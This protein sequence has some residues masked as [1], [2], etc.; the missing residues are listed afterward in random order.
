MRKKSKKMIY[1]P[2]EHI[3]IGESVEVDGQPMLRVKKPN[4]NVYE[5]VPVG[6][7]LNGIYGR[8]GLQEV[9]GRLPQG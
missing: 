8:G 1:S 2:Q 9:Q 5:D 7:L 4:A 3:P 6:T